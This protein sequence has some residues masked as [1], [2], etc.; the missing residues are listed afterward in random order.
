MHG[1]DRHNGVYV[2]SYV[3]SSPDHYKWNNYGPSHDSD[4]LLN[5]RVRDN[6]K[7]GIPNYLDHDDNNNGVPDDQDPNQYQQSPVQ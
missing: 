2:R 7:D 5:P 6:D 1:Y 4:Q 3:R